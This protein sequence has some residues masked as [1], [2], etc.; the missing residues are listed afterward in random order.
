[1]PFTESKDNKDIIDIYQRSNRNNFQSFNST[2]YGG[3]ENSK[4][5]IVRK[6]KYMSND[7][8]R[9]GIGGLGE[10]S[11]NVDTIYRETRDSR[12]ASRNSHNKRNVTANLREK[13]I[14]ESNT[15]KA[16]DVG[17]DSRKKEASNLTPGQSP[18]KA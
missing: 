18:L 17:T 7:S 16:R 4:S 10:R 5:R 1:M 12:N 9:L 3:K 8:V 13:S 6:N 2:V 15:A 11:V 14:E